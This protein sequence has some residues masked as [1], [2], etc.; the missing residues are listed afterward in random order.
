MIKSST[1][2]L[3]EIAASAECLY[4][5]QSEV[6]SEIFSTC[7]LVR[8]KMA[9]IVEAKS[10]TETEDVA[11]MSPYLETIDLI[12]AKLGNFKN[13]YLELKEAEKDLLKESAD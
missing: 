1:E 6:A 2:I 10:M 7:M 13:R 12:D 5:M 4:D 9:K 11:Q 3:D 8:R